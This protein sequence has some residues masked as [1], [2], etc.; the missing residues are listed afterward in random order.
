M[1]GKE[2]QLKK[3]LLLVAF[4][5][6][7]MLKT[8][9]Q[10]NLRIRVNPDDATGGAASEI[11]EEI[12]YIPLETKKASVFGKIDQLFITDSLFLILD[13]DINAILIFNKNGRFHGKIE[14]GSES[15]TYHPLGIQAFFVDK[16]KGEIKYKLGETRVIVHNFNGE[17]IREETTIRSKHVYIFPNDEI[18]FFYY[19]SN[20][21]NNQEEFNNELAWQR[22]GHTYQS[23]LTYSIKNPVIATSDWMFKNGTP[24]YEGGNDTIVFYSRPFD[25]TIYQVSPKTFIDKYSFLFPASFSLPPD[26]RTKQ[27][28]YGKR[29]S[30]LREKYSKSVIAITNFNKV[31][32]TICFS[33]LGLTFNKNNTFFYNL[34]SSKL[35]SFDH[36]TPGAANSFLPLKAGFAFTGIHTTDGRYFYS[37]VS[38]ADMFNA[39]SINSRRKLKYPGAINTYFNKGSKNDNPVIVQLKIKSNMKKC[40]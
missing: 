31:G 34:E 35:I 3:T 30:L 23:A 29:F 37:S 19:N 10:G 1:N 14:G 16:E 9:G 20:D 40:V 17:K 6:S 15:K 12:N 22:N 5:F 7:L 18:V 36:I 38:S 39:K 4:C 25:Y 13:H 32:E 26:F 8:A 2:K 21:K 33:L 28:Y 27:E 24:F 11:F